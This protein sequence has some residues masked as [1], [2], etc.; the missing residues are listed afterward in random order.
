MSEAKKSNIPW[1]EKYRPQSAK[2]LIGFEKVINKL[3]Q[4][5]DDFFIFQ[6]KYRNLRKEIKTISDPPLLKKKKLQLKSFQLKMQ[7]HKAQILIGPPGVGKTT[8]VYA[9]ANDYN[10]SVIELNA[11]DVRTEDAIQNKL[12]ETVK[13]TNL[14]SFTSKKSK[15]KIIL[16]D[17]VDGL[18]GQSDRGGVK[19]LVNIIAQSKFPLILTCNFRDKKLKSLFDLLGSIDISQASA[20]DISK[21]LRKIS[22]Y[23]NLDISEDQIHQLAIGSNGDYRSSIN[24]LQALTQSSHSIDEETL[25]NINIKRDTETEVQLFMNNMFA[26]Y[27][28]KDTKKIIDDVLGPGIDFRSIHKWI[29]E[30]LLSYITKRYDLYY[31][32]ENLAHSDRILGY[33]GRTQDYAHLSYYFDILAGVRYAKSDKILPKDKKVRPPRWFR[34]RAVPDDEVA[35][36]LQKLYTLSLNSI[37]KEIRPNLNLFLKF[38]IGIKEYLASVLQE[39]VKK[40][41]KLIAN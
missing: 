23:E 20:K 4:F 17:E 12:Q 36:S 21:V 16:I 24:D 32:F 7:R 3:K 35:L 13:S 34:T 11:S 9:L 2:D 38:P 8:I 25:K 27:R 40:I 22:K 6:A 39:D 5:L 19:A 37:M 10:M 31:A 18:H 30:N 41:P 33:V 29:N 26:T 1:V 28:I 14:L 15:G